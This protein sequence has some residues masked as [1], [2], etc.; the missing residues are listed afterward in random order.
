LI[1]KGITTHSFNNY[2]IDGDKG[3][4]LMMGY[5]SVNEKLIKENV[6]KMYD[7]YLDFLKI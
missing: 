7:I 1:N 6:Y 4:G 3:N 5:C 2:F